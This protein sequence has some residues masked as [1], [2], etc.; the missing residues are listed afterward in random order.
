M[1]NEQHKNKEV[2]NISVNLDA[3]RQAAL[4]VDEMDNLMIELD[5]VDVR[6]LKLD[7]QIF[8]F[9]SNPVND[10]TKVETPSTLRYIAIKPIVVSGLNNT[11]K[12][13]FIT[14]NG[15]IDIPKTEKKATNLAN[16]FVCSEGEAKAI[17]QLLTKIEYDKACAIA[18]EAE[19]VKVFLKKQSEDN[20]F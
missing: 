11:V 5:A 10:Q 16:T 13:G 9:T 2:L 19:E 15:D 4:N 17:A 3:I 6:S 7:D 20:R 1:N 18:K 8:G 14:I 12:P